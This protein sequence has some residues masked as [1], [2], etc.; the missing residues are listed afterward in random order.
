MPLFKA[1]L[2][3]MGKVTHPAE[4]FDTDCCAET[5]TRVWG[6]R[7]ISAVYTATCMLHAA[8]VAR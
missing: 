4:G 2:P 8:P 3:A 6:Y 1:A 7:L 5:P